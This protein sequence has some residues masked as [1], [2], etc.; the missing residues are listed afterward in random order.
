LHESNNPAEIS[1]R[2][3]FAVRARLL[4]FLSGT[5]A[6]AGALALIAIFYARAIL[7]S[8]SRLAI[9]LAIAGAM[10]LALIGARIVIERMVLEPLRYL[11]DA[12]RDIAAGNL[13]RRMPAT[14]SRELQQLSA[15]V[16]R[17]AHRAFDDQAHVIR[18]ENLATIGRLAASLAHEV[19]NPLGAIRGQLHVL[20]K[21]LR[22]GETTDAVGVCDALEHECTR[23]E[24]IVRG[25]LDYARTRMPASSPVPVDEVI[26]EA[27]EA[28]RARHVLVG[29]HLTIDLPPEP[30][31]VTGERHDL[32]QAFLQLFTNAIEVMN[33]RGRLAVRLERA[34]R[35]TLREPAHR[36]DGDPGVEHPPSTRA[37]RWLSGNDATEIAKVIVADS[38]PGVSPELVDRIFDPFFTTKAVGRGAGLGLAMVARIVENFQGTVWVTHA[39]EGGAAFHLLFPAGASP[40]SVPPSMATRQRRTPAVAWTRIMD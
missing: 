32:A 27:L 29:I 33:G 10:L 14:R 13:T 24:R 1:P 2:G 12:A 15:H 26:R 38:G 16:D 18:S 19:G 3:C 37:Q 23:L 30:L 28:L 39:R 35:F 17:I 36:R 20:R 34:A 5:F 40:A 9:G 8:G 21:E 11:T 4:L 7:P 31:F 6:V 22:E 25:L